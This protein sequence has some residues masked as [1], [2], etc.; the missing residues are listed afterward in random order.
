MGNKR[1]ACSLN[2]GSGNG[3]VSVSAEGVAS[4]DAFYRKQAAFECAIFFDCGIS[5]LMQY[6]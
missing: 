1:K 3:V 6:W 2:I 5:G 4:G